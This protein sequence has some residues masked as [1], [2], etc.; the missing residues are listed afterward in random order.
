MVI[1]LSYYCYFN[2]FR[3][4]TNENEKFLLEKI[5][6]PAK[7]KNFNYGFRKGYPEN[8]VPLSSSK[9]DSQHWNKTRTS[10]IIFPIV[11]T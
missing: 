10:K 6:K 9:I 2:K 8:I 7:K 3:I 5:W 4:L 1:L 11:T